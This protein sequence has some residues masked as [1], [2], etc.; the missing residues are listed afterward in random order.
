MCLL[1]IIFMAPGLLALWVYQH[2]EW[3][4]GSTVNKGQLLTPPVPLRALQT[5]PNT[6]GLVFWSPKGCGASS[7]LT[8]LDK[9]ARIR[10]ALGRRLYGVD[11]WLVMGE[12]ADQLSDHEKNLLKEGDFRIAQL[13]TEDSAKLSD[14]TPSPRFFI[15][16]PERYLVLGY[17]LDAKSEDIFKDLKLLLNSSELNKG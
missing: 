3:L 5:R 11:Q 2:P 9:L 16:S 15:I 4:R 12:G 13:P 1:A 17:D 8:H 10:L 14:L 7:C 6:W